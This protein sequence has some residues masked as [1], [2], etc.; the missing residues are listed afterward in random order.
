MAQRKAKFGKDVEQI[1]LS[2][3]AG[4]NVKCCS[5]AEN[6]LTV[7]YEIKYMTQ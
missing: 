5:H 6:T 7:S 3:I 2:H 1:D 4:R